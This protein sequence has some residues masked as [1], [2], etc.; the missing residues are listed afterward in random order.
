MYSGD[1]GLRSFIM[2]LDLENKSTH[3][4]ASQI[5][6][7]LWVSIFPNSLEEEELLIA[8]KPLNEFD[9]DIDLSRDTD[10]PLRPSC[11]FILL[12]ISSP[13]ASA[14]Q[15]ISWGRE[16]LDLPLEEIF[17]LSSAMGR[18]DILILIK[19]TVSLQEFL[20]M[21]QSRKY[22]ALYLPIE[23][24]H[25][26]ILN[27][28]KEINVFTQLPNAIFYISQTQALHNAALNNKLET[29]QSFQAINS[30]AKSAI[31][32]VT[33]AKKFIL[34][35]VERDHLRILE[36]VE[37]DFGSS[38]DFFLVWRDDLVRQVFLLMGE[39]AQL[40]LLNFFKQARPAV[41]QKNSNLTF[42]A[43]IGKGRVEV[44][45]W[46]KKE[47]PE[48]LQPIVR[49]A[50][51][52]CNSFPRALAKGHLSV[53]QW[54][55]KEYPEYFTS[56]VQKFDFI[57]AART[58][59]NEFHLPLLQWLMQTIPK[60]FERI[61]KKD[62]YALFRIAAEPCA[63]L[64]G[65]N[66]IRNNDLAAAQWFLLYPPCFAYA[67]MNGHEYGEL[68]AEFSGKILKE[69]HQESESFQMERPDQLFDLPDPTKAQQAFYVLRYL[70]R[71]NKRY[72]DNE[73]QFLLNIPAV[74][75][76]AHQ[77]INGGMSNELFRL[78]RIQNNRFAMQML[79][80]IEEVSALARK[81]NFYR[82]DLIQEAKN[83]QRAKKLPSNE[84]FDRENE[85]VRRYKP[86]MQQKGVNNLMSLL[87]VK[88]VQRY[89]QQP[90]MF[91]NKENVQITLP[92]DPQQ[93]PLHEWS[94]ADYQSALR[95][96]A[97]HPDYEAWHYLFTCNPWFHA[98]ESNYQHQQSF[99]W[100]ST[101][102]IY[103]LL[104]METESEI[105]ADYTIESQVNNLDTSKQRVFEPSRNDTTPGMLSFLH[106][107][108]QK[109]I[110]EFSNLL[111]N[112]PP[113]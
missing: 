5:P 71:K 72:L 6:D 51:G 13:N 63:R 70:I 21:L 77:S 75:A 26:S 45:D 67:E 65:S 90:A 88:L 84:D 41:F 43:A 34:N 107:E 92:A 11:A 69:V 110:P 60:I 27:W 111:E 86:L 106:S 18:C 55:A 97:Q 80:S 15:L 112:N 4:V 12:L 44:L 46:F 98:N 101:I 105:L 37:K 29:L 7:N 66:I 104:A 28:F 2:K 19:N 10:L 14:E 22:A 100:Q 81:N 54:L 57:T 108:P 36:W 103:F 82:Q 96:Y 85:V 38:L 87:R 25:L 35:M 73:L 42:L 61:L 1:F 24:G 53:M 91:I 40:D 74:R 20:A 109:S 9:P 68:V 8:Q 39:N 58:N 93:L 64:K 32:K 30:E 3:P 95:A 78:A 16:K 17:R 79:F 33:E 56:V 99:E 59:N 83:Y 62:D 89:N 50:I 76:L 48:S 113:Q 52:A 49:A 47:E 94:K 31:H 102:L 23:N